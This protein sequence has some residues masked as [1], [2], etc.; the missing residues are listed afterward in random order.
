MY[1]DSILIYSQNQTEYRQ[2][3]SL[4]LERLGKFQLFLKAEK[5][6]FHQN[7]IQFLGYSFSPQGIQIDEGKLEAVKSWPV[8]KPV[9][10][11]LRLLG[12]ANF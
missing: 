11:L 12:F 8:P 4:V 7:H 9:K 2:H 6:L 5:S 10:N 1:I 3:M